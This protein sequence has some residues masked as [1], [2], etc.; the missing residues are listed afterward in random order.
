MR[1]FL[2]DWFKIDVYDC[3]KYTVVSIHVWK[4]TELVFTNKWLGFNKRVSRLGER[5]IYTTTYSIGFIGL[6]M[7][8]LGDSN[9]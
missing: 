1:D 8:R 2:W 5:N 6:S 4:L 9:G 3:G 7:T